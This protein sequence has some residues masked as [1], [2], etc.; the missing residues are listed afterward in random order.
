MNNTKILLLVFC[1][2]LI[3]AC[4]GKPDGM[5]AVKKFELDRYLGKWY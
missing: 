1:A 3:T 5:V 4:T 2:F